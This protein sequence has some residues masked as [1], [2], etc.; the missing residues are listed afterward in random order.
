M[1]TFSPEAGPS[2]TRSSQGSNYAWGV[3]V[4]AAV[5]VET[6]RRGTGS[7]IDPEILVCPIRRP[8]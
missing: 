8:L 6:M 7:L 5:G 2:R 3:G 4:Q 1:E